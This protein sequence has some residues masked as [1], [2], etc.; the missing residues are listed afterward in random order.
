MAHA[1]LLHASNSGN[2]ILERWCRLTVVVGQPLC[3]LL[4]LQGVL[5]VQQHAL[6]AALQG[7]QRHHRRL[8]RASCRHQ[9]DPAALE[10]GDQIL[11]GDALPV[12][13][14][15]DGEGCTT[16]ALSLLCKPL[17]TC[18]VV[19]PLDYSNRAVFLIDDASTVSRCCGS[20]ASVQ[21]HVGYGRY[22]PPITE[23]GLR[24]LIKHKV[25]HAS[26]QRGCEHLLG[27]RANPHELQIFSRRQAGSSRSPA[28]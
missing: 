24:C 17:H 5:G 16:G 3:Q 12:G 11:G 6:H 20:L 27:L 4:H 2:L 8:R 19:H 9:R 25:L 1:G 23:H 7:L 22:L 28:G 14:S 26:L 21:E 18:T 15:H 13:G 10:C